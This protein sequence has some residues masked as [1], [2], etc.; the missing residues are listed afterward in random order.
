MRRR[1]SGDIDRGTTTR[2]GIATIARGRGHGRG[3]DIGR[4]APG[5]IGIGTIGTIVADRGSAQRGLTPVSGLG[6]LILG[7]DDTCQERRRSVEDLA[8]A[9]TKMRRRRMVHLRTLHVVTTTA[10]PLLHAG[11]RPPPGPATDLRLAAM[12]KPPRYP[13][14][15]RRQSVL[16]NWQRCRAT[17]ARST[18]TVQSAS[19]C[20]PRKRKRTRLLRERLG[21]AIISTEDEP[22]F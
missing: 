4:G 7:R 9:V 20:W 18:R 15:T 8:H 16:G 10:D 13:L 19:R 2:T 6:G 1:R 14:R 3:R 17:P 5:R 12:R 11:R 22:S 21:C